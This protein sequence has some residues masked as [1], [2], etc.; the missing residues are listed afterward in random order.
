MRYV[1]NNVRLLKHKDKAFFIY[2]K[3]FNN[4]NINILYLSILLIEISLFSFFSHV[5][6]ICKFSLLLNKIIYVSI[7]FQKTYVI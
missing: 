2:I 5:L 7:M 4:K 1:S 3:M 6:F